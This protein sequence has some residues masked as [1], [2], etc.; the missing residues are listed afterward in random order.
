[1]KNRQKILVM[2]FALAAIFFLS[3]PLYA[4]NINTYLPEKLQEFLKISGELRY[5]FELRD[6]FDF[7]ESIDDEQD[8]HLLRTRLNFDANFTDNLRA[9]VQLQDA[10]ILESE[11]PFT[12]AARD[13]LDLR[14]GYLDFKD[15]FL[16]GLTIRVGRQELS[17]GD[18]RLLGGFNWSNLANNFDAV[19]LIYQKGDYTIDAFV[20]RK[21]IADSHNFNKWDTN[22]ALYGL[23]AVYKGFPKHT[24]NFYYFLRDANKP[25]TFRTTKNKMTEN[26]IGFLL[27][28]KDLNNF[29]YTLQY[30][31]Q[32]GDYGNLDIKAWALIAILG[33]TFEHPWSPRLALEYNHASGDESST[34]NERNTFDN[35]FPTNHLHYGYLDRASLQNLNNYRFQASIKP[36]KK[37][38]LQTDAHFLFLDESADSYYNVARK[39]ARTAAT[40]D[41]DKFLGTDL[42][43]IAKYTLRQDLKLLLGYSHFFTGGFLRDT[44]ANDDANYFYAQTIF[45]F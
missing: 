3:F 33:Y 28:G 35:L 9:F 26:T 16:K 24:F 6:D 8:I 4:E 21:V 2:V 20:S 39:V 32:F 1:M 25:I 34:D 17:Y 37:L 11:F 13:S 41:V 15:L 30:A 10:R 29:D 38:Y 5:R 19:K 7:N 22:D 40:P 12:P 27:K 14:Q 45:N 44:G 43:F 18:Q 36:T 31:Y 23:W 42:D